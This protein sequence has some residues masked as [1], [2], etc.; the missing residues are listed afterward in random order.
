MLF[1]NSKKLS[2]LKLSLLIFT[3]FLISVDA[4]ADNGESQQYPYVSGKALFEAE[5]DQVASVNKSGVNPRAGQVNINSELALNFSK[6]WSIITN[7]IYRPVTAGNSDDP[8]I[9]RSI[10]GNRGF[11][12]GDEGLIVEQLK[13][14]YENEDMKVFFGKFDPDFG[15]AFRD[16]KRLG[17]F[18]GDFTRDYQL[19]EKIGGGI[20]AL[21][22]NSEISFSTFFNDTS[23]LTQSA[24]NQR[25]TVPTGNNVAG[26]TGSLSSYVVSWDGQDLFGVKNLFYNFGYRDLGVNNVPGSSNEIGYVGGLEYSIPLS[27]HTSIVPFFEIAKINHFYGQS[28]LDALYMTSALIAR[29]SGWS[30]TITNVVRN[31]SQTTIAGNT[32]EYQME[33]TL[34]YKFSNNV[35][36]D[37][38]RANIKEGTNAFTAIGAMISYAYKF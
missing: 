30:A 10:L 32:H 36:I 8:S 7:W 19:R 16:E 6:N 31:M 23:G 38:T 1:F 35:A 13:A 25:Y 29:Y 15:S 14:Q 26:N 18:T 5:S 11:G 17:I 2:L 9:Y 24:L 4:F 37:V 28:N 27:L 33:Y 3:S 22:E 12:L 34:G 21:L 20:T